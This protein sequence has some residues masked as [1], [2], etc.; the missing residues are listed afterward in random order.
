MSDSQKE[1]LRRLTCDWGLG[2][3]TVLRRLIKYVLRRVFIKRDLTL[4]TL[5]K[6]YQMQVNAFSSNEFARSKKIHRATVSLPEEDYQKLCVLANE[7]FYTLGT[8]INIFVE[9][10]TAGV[11]A[12]NEIWV[13]QER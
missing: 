2:V 7:G 13:I 5:L 1:V 11:I 9:L 3:S 6:D 10:L 12:Q 4:E 8:L